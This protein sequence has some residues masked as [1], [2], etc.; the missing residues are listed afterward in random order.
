MQTGD[1]GVRVREMVIFRNIQTSLEG[2]IFGLTL[3]LLNCKKNH[4]F[5]IFSA[6]NLSSEVDLQRP[7]SWESL[8]QGSHQQPAND[9]QARAN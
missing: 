3:K 7:T 8:P 4:P 1:N 9:D 5:S 2:S 6:R